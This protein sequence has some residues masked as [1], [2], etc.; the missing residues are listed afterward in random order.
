MRRYAGIGGQFGEKSHRRLLCDVRQWCC[1]QRSLGWKLLVH[2]GSLNL[3]MAQKVP[4]WQFQSSK[5]DLDHCSRAPD[6]GLQGFSLEPNIFQVKMTHH[7][8]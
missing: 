1:L 3:N 8:T 5:R 6:L 7:V 2:V 4:G